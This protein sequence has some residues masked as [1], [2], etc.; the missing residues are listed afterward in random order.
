MR[1]PLFGNLITRR[2]MIPIDRD[3]GVGAI[4]LL[5]ELDRA[6]R[7]GSQI[8]DLPGRHTQR[9]GQARPLHPASWRWRPARGCR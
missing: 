3:A 7:E 4:I 2:R 9:A 5:R 8:V 6:V 1:I